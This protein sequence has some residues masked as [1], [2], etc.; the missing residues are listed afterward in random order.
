MKR[1]VVVGAG[2]C[3][4]V[5]LKEMLEH[6]HNVTLY[7]QEDRLGGTFA[8][9]A[10]YPNLHLTIT[11]WAMAF[12]DFPDPSRLHYSTAEEY[13]QYL[14]A[15]TDHFDLERHNEKRF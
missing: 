5:A 9:A 13:L 15:Y 4:L 14:Q 3:G 7:E 1:V 11:N 12:S 10:A 8:S 6:G 2:P